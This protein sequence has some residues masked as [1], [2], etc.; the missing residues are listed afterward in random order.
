MSIGTIRGGVPYVLRDTVTTGTAPAGGRKVRLP[1]YINYLMIRVT[2]NACRLFFTEADYLAASGTNY[3][4]IQP[5]SA[6]YPNGEWSGP[7]ETCA[8]TYSDIWLRGDAGSSVLE[9]VG[10]QRRG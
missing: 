3:V 7:V 1:F 5:A 6:T 4:L 9:L 8:G 10:F 2:T